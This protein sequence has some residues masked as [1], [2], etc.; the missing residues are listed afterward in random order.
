M[1]K[2]KFYIL[3]HN[4]NTL[5]EAEEFLK[6]GANALE[7]DVCFDAETPDRFFV[8]HGTLGSNPF[9]RE[10]SLVTYLQGLRRMLTDAGNGYNLALIAFDIKTPEFDINE[11]INVVFD[12]FS[13]HP[14]CSG[15]AIL[16][17]VSSLSD[18]GFLNAFDQ[19]KEN[20]AVGVDEEKSAADVEAGFRS[21]GQR[22]FTYAN[23]SIVSDIKFGL[24]SS[25]MRAK[26]L[27]A[28]SGGDGFKLVYT[29]VL[30]RE[31]PIRS[32]LDLHID[33]IIVDVDVVPHLLKILSDEHFLPMY[34]LAQNGYNPFA[35]SPPPTYLLNI[36]TRAASFAGTDVPVRFTLQG[37]AG[38]LESTLDAD[39]RGVLE[40]G[41]E[42][43]LTLE[44]EDIGGIISLTIAAQGSGLNPGWLPETITLESSLLPAP[45]IFQYGADEWL[46][47]GHA[48]TKTPV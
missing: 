17:T 47:L 34:E 26:R 3:A 23:G 16:I 45:L 12:N 20:V 24:F 11:F 48:V 36:K 29:W 44:G 7:P 25:I 42:D 18:I 10:H 30:A 39:F 35:Q 13:A 22:R 15:V 38:V 43:F 6:A 46:M 41:G 28:R 9:T 4:P 19:T 37:S 21:G 8:S 33:G 31:S 14:V 2:Q 5:E 27:Q 32:F 40:R 1:Q